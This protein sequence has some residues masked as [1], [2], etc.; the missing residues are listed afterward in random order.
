MIIVVTISV[1]ATAGATSPSGATGPKFVSS[2]VTDQRGDVVRIPVR[3]PDS[4]D[5]RL[6][7]VNIQAGYDANLTLSDRNHDGIATLEFNT[8]LAGTRSAFKTAADDDDVSVLSQTDVDGP[9]PTG[10]YRL[11]IEEGAETAGLKIERRSTDGITTMVAPDGAYEHLRTEDAVDQYRHAGNLTARRSGDPAAVA[12]RDTLVLRISASGISGVLASQPGNN[13][14]ERFRALVE[15]D[16][17]SFDV[18][19]TNPT[20]SQKRASLLVNRSGLHVVADGRSDRYYV[21]VDTSRAHYRRGEDGTVETGL[22]V[23]TSFEANVTVAADSYL[24][25]D[26]PRA[27]EMAFEVVDRSAVIRTHAESGA[28]FLQPAAGQ[29]IEGATTVAPGTT[30]ELTIEGTAADFSARKSVTVRGAD[31]NGTF[32]ATI[33]IA[34]LPEGTTL[35]AT[36]RDPRGS[37]TDEPTRV[38]VRSPAAEIGSQALAVEGSRLYATVEADLSRGGLITVRANNASGRLLGS[39]DVDPGSNTVEVPLENLPGKDTPLVI[40][41]LRDIDGDGAVSQSV[42][43][44]Y[45]ESNSPRPVQVTMALYRLPPSPTPSPV[46]PG[47]ETTASSSTPPEGTPDSSDTPG[48]GDTTDPQ[49]TPSPDADQLPVGVPGFGAATALVALVATLLLLARR[50]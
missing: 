46:G 24:G 15:S 22:P 33:D 34:E 49:A 8:Y 1:L 26:A 42:D 39:T 20:T 37:L 45:E 35:V 41:A 9:L 25:V 36:A 14:T 48:P 32:E 16:V 29:S 28:Y 40:T 31:G 7:I 21:V 17:L 18:L 47:T 2:Y 10:E 30:V 5:A 23:G 3:M 50:W 19:E 12:R 38:T 4:N 27:A 11:R 6:R 43:V 44:P 13:D